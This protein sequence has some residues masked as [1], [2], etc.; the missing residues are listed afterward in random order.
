MPEAGRFPHT[1]WG[2]LGYVLAD[3][4]DLV[5]RIEATLGGTAAPGQAV[6]AGDIRATQFRV[7]R[8][9][10]HDQIEVDAGLDRLAE[11][12]TRQA[13]RAGAS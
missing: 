11:E 9:G 4:D 7:T 10:G 1:R 2:S 8:R 3:V 13:R 5:A 6:A 12:L